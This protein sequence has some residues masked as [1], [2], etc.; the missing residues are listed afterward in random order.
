MKSALNWI[1]C[2]LLAALLAFVLGSVFAT[3][4]I[5]ANVASLGLDVDLAVR[6]Q[7]TVH[8]LLGLLPSYLPLVA[9]ALLLGLPVAAGL[10][11]WLPTQ[12]LLLYVIA[13]AV[14]VITV[15]LLIKAILGLSGFA[16][17]RTLVGLALQ[18]VA[19]ALG[20][21]LFYRLRQQYLGA[22]LIDAGTEN[23]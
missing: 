19:G 4:V 15:H 12:G 11:R 10:S 18:G 1:G 14:A 7:S 13:G 5:L 2:W 16:A 20:G 21:L 22:T 3:Q 17:A 9:V 6:M 23:S 8:D